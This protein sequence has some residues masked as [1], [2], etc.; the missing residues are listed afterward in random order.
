[1]T[2]CH[3]PVLCHEI[4]KELKELKIKR[5]F[6]GTIGAGG[7]AKL[8]LESHPEIEH[9]IG[10]DQDGA[11]LEHAER[12]LHPWHSKVT[13]FQENFSAIDD[14]LAD[15]V[16][17]LLFDIGVSSLQLDTASRG[18]SFRFDAPLDM[19]MD[20]RQTLSAATIV[21]RYPQR[22]IEHILRDFGEERHFKKLA[23]AIVTARRKKPFV[24][25]FDLT[26][27]I[28]ATI[29]RGNYKINSATRTFQALRIFVNKEL[30]LLE[31][32]LKAS[33]AHMN[34]NAKALVIS[35]HSL[36]DRIVKTLFREQA[37]TKGFNCVKKPITAT[38]AEIGKNPRARSAKLRWLTKLAT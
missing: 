25:T 5:F 6:D 2:S 17:G 22:E 13:L 3:K 30:E 21:N 34:D 31:M 32:G 37:A 18:F 33:F 15:N 9:Y 4:L 35:F 7:H 10:C 1:M 38:K 23:K 12:T 24:S 28:Y 20:Q 36:E 19:R 11:I 27:L 14:L 26:A 16:D 29:G 8:I